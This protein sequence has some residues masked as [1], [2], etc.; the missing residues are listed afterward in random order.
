MSNFKF[1]RRGGFAKSRAFYATCIV[2][3]IAFGAAAFFGLGMPSNDKIG[4][5]ADAASQSSVIYRPIAS[6]SDAAQNSFESDTPSSTPSKKPTSSATASAFKP[7]EVTDV[8][9]PSANFFV[10]PLTGEIIKQY[11]DKELQYSLT[12]GDWR[13]HQSVDIKGVTGER[14]NAAGDGTVTAVYE[15]AVYGLTVEIN[16]GN[17]VTA[18]YS[19]LES[20]SVNVGDIVG[21]N[22]EIGTLGKVPC[23]SVE[24]THLHFSMRVGD[25]YV[26]PMNMIGVGN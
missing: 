6:E 21:A 12:L 17:E 1:T 26:S 24:T 4:N 8:G 16:H 25:N 3:L 23:E 18:I 7:S 20:A 11:N 15:N 13:M 22:M 2:S 19:G 9:T 14:I 5:T 10:M